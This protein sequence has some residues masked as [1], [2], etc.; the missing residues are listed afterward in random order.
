MR[1]TLT[2]ILVL[3]AFAV[4][5]MGVSAATASRGIT[6]TIIPPTVHLA[7]PPTASATAVK[8][9][10]EAILSLPASQP[11]RIIIPA[12]GV[13]APVVPV[14]ETA[15]SVGTPPLT[16]HDLA[17]WYDGSVTPGQTGP[18]LIDGHID[19]YGLASV[20]YR[21]PALKTG[22]VIRVLLKDGET[23][24]FKVTWVQ[25][26]AKMAFPWKTVLGWTS[27]PSLR[28][29]TCGG[30]FNSLTGHYVDNVIVYATGQGPGT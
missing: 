5:G 14:S 28:L 19:G 26:V 27:Y 1:R 9:A 13:N 29:V 7:P 22:D 6:S 12:I 16:N 15:G 18:S 25:V 3:A 11:V 10:K 21:L 30:P 20:F 17:G 2:T 4:A 8:Q 23:A 24:S